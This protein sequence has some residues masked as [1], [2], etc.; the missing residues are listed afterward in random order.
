MRIVRRW[1]LI[2]VV[3]AALL[4]G[5]SAT[6]WGRAAAAP[7]TRKGGKKRVVKKSA[8]R[9]QGRLVCKVVK[10]QKKCRRV[11]GKFAGRIAPANELRTEPLPQPSGHIHIFARNTKDN[12]FVGND[13]NV[14]RGS[15]ENWQQ[16]GEN[17][18]WDNLKAAGA[19]GAGALAG[20]AAGNMM[21]DRNNQ[22]AAAGTR[23]RVPGG[24]IGGGNRASQLPA[25]TGQVG[26]RM[27]GRANTGTAGTGIAQQ[28]SSGIGR[29]RR[30]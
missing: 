20:S 25:N 4:L 2:V 28:P 26:D 3:G 1:G 23:E 30:A 15:G 17:G 24:T 10:G 14:Y 19:A 9:N 18:K 12:M 27:A 11:R 22:G 21:R 8:P 16:L 5:H 7:V 29:S 13:G 6:P